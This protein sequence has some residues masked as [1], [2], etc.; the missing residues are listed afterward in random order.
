MATHTLERV[1]DCRY[2]IFCTTKVFKIFE[3]YIYTSQWLEMKSHFSIFANVIPFQCSTKSNDSSYNT[4][5]D[6]LNVT[7][8][9]IYNL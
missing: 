3:L 7:D 5:F 8:R 6:I 4:K 9:I 1:R 2:L